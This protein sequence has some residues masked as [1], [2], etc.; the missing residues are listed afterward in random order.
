MG[1]TALGNG[2]ATRGAAVMEYYMRPKSVAVI[3]FSSKPGSAGMNA[4]TNLTTNNFAG[5]IYLVGRSGG[6]VEGR[7]VFTEIDQLPEGV[8]L[9]IF[10]LPAAGVKEAMEGC[11][12]RKVKATVIFAS[13]FAEVGERA[14]QD[15]LAKIAR[16]GN[17]ALLGPNCLGYSNF[18][19][20]FNAFFVS[21]TT[22]QKI[23]AKP[24]SAAAVIS[25]SGG[26]MAHIRQGLDQRDI[27]VSYNLSSGNEAGVGLADFVDF[28]VE[29]ETTASIII[30]VEEVRQPEAF[31]AAARRAMAAGKPVLMVHPGSSDKGRDAV[32]SHTGAL[33]GNHAVMRTLVTHAGIMFVDTID[34]LIDSAEIATRYPKSP[35]NGPG[36]L[37]F[38]GAFCALAHDFLDKLDLDI[39][40]L[41]AAQEAELRKVMPSFATPR[42]PLDL[43]TQPV[44]Q[45]ELV[46]QGA[47]ALLDDPAM[48]SMVISIPI[49]PPVL[50]MKYLDGITKAIDSSK[51]PVVFSILGERSPLPQEFIDKA[52]EKKIIISR[53]AERSMRAMAQVTFHGR[54]VERAKMTVEAKP[55]S[56]LPSFGKGTQA[57][58]V[59]KLAL[60]AAGIRIPEGDLAR[61]ADQAVQIAGKIGY[62]VVMKAQAA[63]L[64]HKT[65]AGGV[66]L[67]LADEAAVRKAWTT[68]HE[69]VERYQPGL[70]LDGVLVEKMSSKGLEFI[71]G[72]RRDP[73]WG[74]VVVVGIGGVL[75]EA[76]GDVRLLPPDLS[77]EAIVKE[78]YKLKTAKLLDGFRGSPAVDVEAVAEVAVKV[79]N[80]MR[81]VPEIMEIDINPVFAHPRGQGVTA[82]DALIVT[83]N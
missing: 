80:L 20:G 23:E 36:F 44:W 51:K 11:V 69:N 1:E 70:K 30:Y 83:K 56:G 4:L 16:D 60:K 12:R 59:G 52:K 28:F 54:A 9:A 64:A 2:T 79:G 3:G 6:E 82:L 53:S 31:L 22:V 26:L 46:G 73:V 78:L 81:T 35:V 72:S 42:N 48:G 37:T 39:P 38:S 10:T 14:K 8:D 43:T 32:N 25:Q 65:E 58:W 24:R 66:L 17:V 55:I 18:I 5:D 40:P 62:P 61:S 27:P 68:L 29:D 13:G 45:P 47:Q 49:G 33:A 63:K 19:T 7:K 34:E 21:A 15:E 41:S 50:A 75:I 67:N 74:P 76:I 71:V 77:K 57:E